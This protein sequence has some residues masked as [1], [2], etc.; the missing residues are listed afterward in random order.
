[1]PRVIVCDVSETLLGVRALEPDFK[2]VFGDPHAL[3]DWF[4]IA[5]DQLRLVAAHAW[6][7]VGA[8]GHHWSRQD[9]VPREPRLGGT[10]VRCALLSW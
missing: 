2:D 1:M 6:D 10:L 3:Q 8:P 7:I 4:A 5:I 9:F